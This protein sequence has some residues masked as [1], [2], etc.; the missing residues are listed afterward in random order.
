MAMVCHQLTVVNNCFP[1][2][3]EETWRNPDTSLCLMGR[4]RLKSS[5]LLPPTPLS[6]PPH[7]PPPPSPT[8]PS[9]EHHKHHG[10]PS[11]SPSVSVS[12][13]GP[14]NSRL[15]SPLTRTVAPVTASLNSYQH[16]HSSP[17]P[18]T[19]RMSPEATPLAPSPSSNVTSLSLTSVP[20]PL[21][22]VGRPHTGRA[23][24]LNTT[25]P[26]PGNASQVCR[27]VTRWKRVGVAT[28]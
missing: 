3:S 17:H 11:P 16:G 27:M 8:H 20:A 14:G 23:E 21:P 7:L 24:H 25:P 5:L 26:T 4:C 28:T 12:P 6:H 15:A 19:L 18:Q 22:P 2:Y 13:H 10:P 9:P 1:G